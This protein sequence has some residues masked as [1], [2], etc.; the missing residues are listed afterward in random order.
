MIELRLFVRQVVVFGRQGNYDRRR[1]LLAAF[2]LGIVEF[3]S[4]PDP[5][6]ANIVLARLC[7]RIAQKDFL[8]SHAAFA[9][10]F[11]ASISAPERNSG[12]TF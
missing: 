9:P 1:F 5:V 11:R 12:S 3:R 10:E 8:C 2:N 7:G 4:I 6:A